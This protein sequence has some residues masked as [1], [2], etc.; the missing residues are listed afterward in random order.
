MVVDFHHLDLSIS[1]YYRDSQK[2]W[3]NLGTFNKHSKRMKGPD[4]LQQICEKLEWSL[5]FFIQI[6][7]RGLVSYNSTYTYKLSKEIGIYHVF[8]CSFNWGVRVTTHPSIILTSLVSSLLKKKSK[9]QYCTHLQSISSGHTI[10]VHISRVNLE[11]RMAQRSIQ[12]SQVS[13]EGQYKIVY[14]SISTL[15]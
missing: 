15:L 6:F 10:L 5:L 13:W 1:T 11:E 12:S 3:D 7:E 2:T 9:L 4:Q 8:S 14:S